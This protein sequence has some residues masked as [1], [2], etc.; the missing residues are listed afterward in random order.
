MYLENLQFSGHSADYLWF[1]ILTV[2]MLT[3]ANSYFELAVLW[4]AFSM[5]IVHLWAQYNKAVTVNFMFGFRFP[6]QY[7][8]YLD[9]TDAFRLFICR[10]P[11]WHTSSLRLVM[12]PAR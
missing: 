9:L 10:L 7:I 1:L 11:C 4:E 5:A 12:R 3:L 8:H 2:S 6:V